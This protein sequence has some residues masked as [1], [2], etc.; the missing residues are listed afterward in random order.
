MSNATELAAPIDTQLGVPA[1]MSHSP[2]PSPGMS[3]SPTVHSGEE[4]DLSDPARTLT[5]LPA[6]N[7]KQKKVDDQ[8]RPEG[9]LPVE[10]AIGEGVAKEYGAEGVKTISR[11]NS[12]STL[13]S[14]KKN[15]LLL[16]FCLSMF[17]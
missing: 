16:C 11:E 3:R 15:V 12:L 8:P 2:L 13:P 10:S 4:S 17:M 14:F 5:D 1:P 9:E 6:T 7:E